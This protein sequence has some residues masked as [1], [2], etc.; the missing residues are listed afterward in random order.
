MFEEAEALSL[1][2][3]EKWKPVEKKYDD[4]LRPDRNVK[5]KSWVDV[6]KCLLYLHSLAEEKYSQKVK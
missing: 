1:K 5:L 2:A 6:A 4:I 3:E